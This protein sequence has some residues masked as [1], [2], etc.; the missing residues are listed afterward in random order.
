M[1]GA[2][3][4]GGKL[5]HYSSLPST[6]EAA[7][8]EARRGVAE[9]TVVWADEQLTGRG[10]KGRD[11]ISPRGGLFLSVVLR[12]T[13]PQ[14]PSLLM[15]ASVAMV[16]VLGRLF[17]LHARL[18]W[19]NDVLI[20]G[21]KVS[22]VLVE[23]SFRGEVLEYAVIGMGLNAN[24]DPGAYPEVSATATSLSRELGREVDLMEVLD[25]LL[26]E[27]DGLYRQLRAGGSVFDEWRGFL[28]TL[29]QRV[30]VIGPGL[31]EEGLAQDVMADGRLLLLRKDGHRIEIP[32]GEVSLLPGC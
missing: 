25:A 23:S 18:K 15:L 16:R 32:A 24:F 22:G 1:A 28:E 5:L 7:A 12:P 2:R 19:P 27:L 20:R 30:R 14:L 3:I 13:T 21:K 11:W 9:G 10:R 17:R 26:W 31:E 4:I 8:R 29:G 6:M